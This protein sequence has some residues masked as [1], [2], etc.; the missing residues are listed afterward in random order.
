MQALEKTSLAH[1]DLILLDMN[2]PI[3]GGKDFLKELR[4]KDASLPV[5]A[6][7]SNSMLDDKLD[8]FNAGVDDYMT[9]PFELQ[10]LLARVKA[11]LKR[12]EKQAQ[13]ILKIDDIEV[14]TWEHKV[15]KR[16]KDMDFSNKQ[17]L[18]VE[19][20]MQ[21]RWFPQ[22]KAKI[23]EHVWGE[24]EENLEFNS[25]TLEAHISTIRKKLGKDFI[26][27]MKGVG[28]VIE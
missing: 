27:T 21:N 14:F 17:Y 6:L 28:Y 26:G 9:K 1:Y 2:M 8:M 23:F 15:Y 4:K 13:D 5:L 18:I 19:F 7:T 24:L 16:G 10:E 20:L 3:L 11:L 22:S 25:T 12:S